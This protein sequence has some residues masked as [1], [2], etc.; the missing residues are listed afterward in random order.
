MDTW[1]LVSKVADLNWPGFLEN[2]LASCT[3]QQFQVGPSM[4]T[5]VLKWLIL[6]QTTPNTFKSKTSFVHLGC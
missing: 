6:W 2:F 3:L 4:N 1:Y 5:G